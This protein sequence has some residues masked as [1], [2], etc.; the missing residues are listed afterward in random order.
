MDAENKPPQ[1]ASVRP[2]PLS[3][4]LARKG[5][6]SPTFPLGGQPRQTVRLDGNAVRPSAWIARTEKALQR[7]GI[8]ANQIRIKVTISL[9][10]Y[11]NDFLI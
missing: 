5:T 7:N 3:T 9:E 11:Y 1:P 8:S 4:D 2:R 6:S 10:P